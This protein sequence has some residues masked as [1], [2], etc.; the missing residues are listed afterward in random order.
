MTGRVWRQGSPA[1][2]NGRPRER[3]EDRHY[4]EE[5]RYPGPGVVRGEVR[6]LRSWGR[7]GGQAVLG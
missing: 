5:G 6:S 1:R 2:D 7:E 3:R 4:R